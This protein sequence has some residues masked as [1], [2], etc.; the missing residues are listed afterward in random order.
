MRFFALVV[1]C[2]GL[3]LLVLAPEAASAKTRHCAFIMGQGPANDPFVPLESV[4]ARNM[5]CAKALG[6]IHSGKLTKSGNLKTKSFSCKVV[7]AYYGGLGV[8]HELLGAS[9]RCSA[10]ASRWFSFS[11]AT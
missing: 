8:D 5:T 2:L 7:H 10:T 9:V 6:A 11:W 4:T 3:A 1:A